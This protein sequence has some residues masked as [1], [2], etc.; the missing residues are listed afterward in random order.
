MALQLR[1][2]FHARALYYFRKRAPHRMGASP[3]EGK[4]MNAE[5]FWAMGGYGLY[6]WG[7]Y[8]FALVVL[9]AE[10]WLLRN[11]KRAL[12]RQL[13]RSAQNGEAKS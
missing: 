3:L 7:S 11:R 12:H 4:R 8:G 1:R 2:S 13:Q 10:V 9:T 5:G 6:V